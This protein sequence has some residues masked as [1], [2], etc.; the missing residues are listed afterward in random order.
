LCYT[1]KHTQTL[2]I[3]QINKTLSDML[4][5][6]FNCAQ[7]EDRG[8]A[9]MHHFD[10]AIARS[11][12]YAQFLLFL[13]LD[14][15]HNLDWK[16]KLFQS[17]HEFMYRQWETCYTLSRNGLL[18]A[19]AMERAAVFGGIKLDLSVKEGSFQEQLRCL[20]AGKQL[21]EERQVCQTYIDP[22]GL[23]P[24]DGDLP[25]TDGFVPVEMEICDE[26]F[27]TS[28]ASLG[29]SAGTDFGLSTS[30]TSTFGSSTATSTGTFAS[31]TTSCATA[32][33]SS[34]CPGNFSLGNNHMSNPT[35]P[36]K[37]TTGHLPNQVA[38][39]PGNVANGSA[40]MP[41]SSNANTGATTANKWKASKNEV[42]TATGDFCESK[43]TDTTSLIS[44]FRN[45]KFQKAL[46]AQRVTIKKRPNA[47]NEV[48]LAHMDILKRACDYIFKRRGLSRT[49]GFD[50]TSIRKNPVMKIGFAK[51]KTSDTLSTTSSTRRCARLTATELYAS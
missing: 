1:L 37:A 35:R 3:F 49:S 47:G 4:E 50:W 46:D 19:E 24:E 23:V 41:P 39:S 25:M 2:I 17:V 6:R 13:G 32:S 43:M 20:N 14:P 8:Q 11:E 15:R 51:W 44:F 42:M 48:Q 34:G 26:K 40:T 29:S 7:F 10:D 38:A 33:A 12:R 27:E 9:L 22:E 31:S 16:I 18:I 36:L 21:K 30:S 5:A 45:P 28:A